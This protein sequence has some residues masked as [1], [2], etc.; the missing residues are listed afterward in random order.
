MK[1]MEEL[2]RFQLL[3]FLSDVYAGDSEMAEQLQESVNVYTKYQLQTINA[4]EGLGNVI[5]NFEAELASLG[6]QK[7]SVAYK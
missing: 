1:D 7:D 6:T 5:A 2:V 3:K 4:A